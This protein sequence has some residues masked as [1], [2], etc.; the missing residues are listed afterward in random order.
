MLPVVLIGNIS[1]NKL[2]QHA[3]MKKF[4]ILP[5]FKNL[6]FLKTKVRNKKAIIDIIKNPTIPVSVNICK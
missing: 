3:R 1:K 4:S 5:P 2:I 6:K